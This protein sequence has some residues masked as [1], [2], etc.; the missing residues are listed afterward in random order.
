MKREVTVLLIRHKNTYLYSLLILL[1]FLYSE[2][3][4]LVDLIYYI[5]MLILQTFLLLYFH[6]LFES[7]IIY[8]TNGGCL[9]CQK[10]IF[11][12]LCQSLR[13][14]DNISLL[15]VKRIHKKIVKKIGDLGSTSMMIVH[16][17]LIFRQSH[18]NTKHG[19]RSENIYQKLIRPHFEMSIK[20]QNEC[21]I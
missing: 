18:G 6:D 12:L 7:C 4:K 15:K 13:R 19:K 9:I 8:H 2:L 5:F 21:V 20:L 3:S 14:L 10:M 17:S 16:M 1:L 11:M